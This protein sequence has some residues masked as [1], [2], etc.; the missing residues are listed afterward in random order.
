MIDRVLQLNSKLRYLSR[1]AIFGGP[2][3]EIMEE[4]RDLF[5]EIYDEIGRPD[6][7]KMIEESLE[8]DRRMGLK[9]ALSNLSEDIAE[10]LYKRINRS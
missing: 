4:L 3:D 6:R 5:R 2:D 10:F 1:Q 9:Y 7:V 8:V